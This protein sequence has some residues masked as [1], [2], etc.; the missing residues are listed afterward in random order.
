MIIWLIGLSASGKTAIGKKVYQL[1]KQSEP[2]TVFVD[3]DEIREIFKHD[4][5]DSPYTIEGRKINADRICELCAWLDRQKINAVCCILS[6][7][8]ES[9]IWN[10][11]NYSDYYEVFI[12]VPLDI[13]KKRDIK[14]LYASAEQGILKNVVGMDI[15]FHNPTT[16][17]LIID[18]SPELNEFDSLANEILSS[19]L[20]NRKKIKYIY[21]KGNLIE[22]PNTYFYS[23][24]MGIDFLTV[25]INSRRKIQKHLNLKYPE[26]LSKQD[27]L[28]KNSSL[29]FNID[30]NL[31]NIK[32]ISI[33]HK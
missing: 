4:R 17:D 11:N 16:Y 9:R 25:W 1:W 6:I 20:Q 26:Y 30:S 32:K 28:L 5:G 27:N 10:R 29:E 24:V 18:N 13:C 12:S 7:F 31:N 14:K 3:G 8:D 22:K 15:P 21:S 2:N 33:L 23:K 19:A